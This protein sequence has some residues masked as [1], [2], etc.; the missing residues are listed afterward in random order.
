[1]KIQ[2]REKNKNLY[3]LKKK[4]KGTFFLFCL[5]FLKNKRKPKDFKYLGGLVAIYY[6]YLLLPLSMEG[7]P[8]RKRVIC[9]CRSCWNNLVMLLAVH[10]GLEQF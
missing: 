6:S 2:K 3:L 1:M 10:Y 7:I 8:R 9:V 5:L 4:K